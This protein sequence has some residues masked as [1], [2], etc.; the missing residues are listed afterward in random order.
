MASQPSPGKARPAEAERHEAAPRVYAP[1]PRRLGVIQRRD[2]VSTLLAERQPIVALT[3]PGGFGKT[4]VLSQWAAAD[5]RPVAWLPIRPEH[6]DAVPLLEEI[7]AA[8]GEI[9]SVDLA[10]TRFLRSPRPPVSTRILPRFVRSLRAAEEPFLLILDDA[11]YLQSAQAIEVLELIA[12]N[13]PPDAQVGV[14]ARSLFAGSSALRAS[15]ALTVFGPRELALS[16]QETIEVLAISDAE[17]NADDVLRSTEGWPIAVSMAAHA[18][19]ERWA[20]GEERPFGGEHHMVVDYVRNELLRGQTP[21]AARFLSESSVLERLSGPL[22]DELLER[23]DSARLLQELAHRHLFLA[24]L[25]PRHEHYALHQLVRDALRAEL[26]RLDPGRRRELDAR[27]VEVLATRGEMDESVR[28][29]FSAGMRETAAG[30]LWRFMTV[31]ASRGRNDTLLRWLEEFTP[32]EE[33]SNPHVA[34]CHAWAYVETRSDLVDLW[35]RRAE[36]SGYEGPLYD[37]MDLTAMTDIL[38]ATIGMD[39]IDG[40]GRDATRAAGLVPEQ[41][42]W[43]ALCHFFQG[44]SLHLLGHSDAA[45][46]RLVEGG[47]IAGEAFP[48]IGMLSAAWLGVIAVFEGD[49]RRAAEHIT[50]SRAL[51]EDWGL[52][53]YGSAAITYSLLAA[54]EAH[55]DRLDEARR[56]FGHARRLLTRIDGVAPFFA[57]TTRLLLAEASLRCGDLSEAAVMRSEGQRSL[58]AGDQGPV[59]RERYERL[60]AALAG[61]D[62]KMAPTSL[63]SAEMRVLLFLPTHLTFR[64]IGER[65]YVSRFT[66]KSQAN[67]IYRKLA[68]SSR[69]DA[70]ERATAIGLLEE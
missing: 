48:T 25:D 66:V 4:T 65:L 17:A 43:R 60:G 40:V 52:D 57:A 31:L 61:L 39:G 26:T 3:A 67:A 55:E 13:L 8:V 18:M 22:C 28:H 19:S 36:L 68:V 46:Q 32:S 54:R 38:R 5:A 34:L 21:E 64:E 29:A 6:D 33:V 20:L 51:V 45:R 37:G 12:T 42:P 69:S 56:H 2:L 44:A 53:E 41:S 62:G 50:A 27:A 70:V 63:T 58:A 15:G 47:A 49:W 23:R 24:P 11:H 7:A 14:G 30:L 16:A 35:T 10:L 9:V 59:L 1:P